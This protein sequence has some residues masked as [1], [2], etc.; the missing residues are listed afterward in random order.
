MIEEEEFELIEL[1]LEVDDP[2]EEEE[3]TLEPQVMEGDITPLDHMESLLIEANGEDYV[4]PIVELDE[5]EVLAVISENSKEKWPD[6]Y[7]MQEFSLNNQEEAYRE[8]LT[9]E[10][11]N[12]FDYVLIEQSFD[13]WDSDFDMVKFN[14]EYQQES[15]VDLWEINNNLADENEE[16]IFIE[17]IDHWGTNFDMVLFRYED[18]LESFDN[19]NSRSP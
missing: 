18:Q 13:K 19:L 2:L 7:S 5:D 15:L 14:Y 1:D 3:P 4:N 8:L 6:D 16:D 9:L 11:D 12:V 17:A 10:I